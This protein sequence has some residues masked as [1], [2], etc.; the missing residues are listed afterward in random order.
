MEFPQH[1]G[2]PPAT[3]QGSDDKSCCLPGA[4]SVESGLHYAPSPFIFAALLDQAAMARAARRLG[5]GSRTRWTKTGR[6]G[7]GP[8]S[9]L[10]GAPRPT[11]R[12]AT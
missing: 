2:V 7:G 5:R 3:C 1:W 4:L 11:A 8:A 6:R 9:R 10:H 12:H